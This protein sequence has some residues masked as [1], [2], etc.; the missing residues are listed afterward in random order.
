M[1]LGVD[2]RFELLQLRVFDAC[3]KRAAQR[4]EGIAHLPLLELFFTAIAHALVFAGT[5]VTAEPIGCDLDAARTFTGADLGNDALDHLQQDR[6]V[7]SIVLL[8]RYSERLR[9]V[10]EL[11]DRLA[12][13][14]R[15]MRGVFVIFADDQ[16]RQLI[17]R[18]KVKNLVSDPLVEDAV[19][20]D[21]NADVVDAPIFL[22]E[23]AAKWDVERPA[24]DRPAVEI[25]LV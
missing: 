22:R 3:R 25:V 6:G 4:G 20:D 24:D 14:D 12:P 18:G 5:D 13:L 16:K 2:A 15:R 7:V 10:D 17:K 23:R 9:A 8:E 11:S 21:G 1:N 19:P